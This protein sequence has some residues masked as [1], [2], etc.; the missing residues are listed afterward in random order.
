[1]LDVKSYSFYHRSSTTGYTNYQ[2]L[3]NGI[4]VGSGS[5]FVSSGS[6]LQSTGTINV[7][8]AIVGLTG[9]VTVT[10][11][12][13]GGS[14]GNNATFRLDDFTLNGYT[15]EVQVYAEGYR[16]GYQNQE[17]DDEIKGAGNSVNYTFRMHDPRVG[18][19]FAVDPLIESYPFYS[20]Y[21]FSG[22]RVIDSKEIEGLE[23]E[24]IHYYN[25][26]KQK[27]GSYKPKDKPE[28]SSEWLTLKSENSY[29]KNSNTGQSKTLDGGGVFGPQ[30]SNVNVYTYWE[31]GE[32]SKQRVV[33]SNNQLDGS[34]FVNWKNPEL[35][36][37]DI[38][39]GVT[40]II[41]A[42]SEGIAS[43]IVK[44]RYGYQSGKINSTSKRVYNKQ[45][46]KNVISG[47]KGFSAAL[48]V[49]QYYNTNEQEN[50]GEISEARANYNNANTTIG[51]GFPFAG[52]AISIGDYYGQ[53]YAP[54]LKESME[55][56]II[57][58]VLETVDKTLDD[59]K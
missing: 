7:A 11:K 4:L 22:N 35:S 40:S 17:K 31:N 6:T 13:F 55:K 46:A 48:T 54:E 14:N 56:G 43:K 59:N 34:E 25:M 9:S 30:T 24:N 16:Y 32:I 8:N 3:V 19:F 23:H 52:L 12:L 57:H 26:V 41:S 51:I 18:R 21:S 38:A 45:T 47:I 10:L 15:Q 42:T 27:D 37:Q 49:F 29:L 20:S 44:S 5:I 33:S 50:N 58:D 1:M 39:L 53:K 36:T 2:L 28:Y